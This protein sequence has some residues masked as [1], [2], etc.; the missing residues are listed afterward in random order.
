MLLT[1][2]RHP[3]VYYTLPWI[4]KN[5]KRNGGNGERRETVFCFYDFCF[6][7]FVFSNFHSSIVSYIL[8]DNVIII[9]SNEVTR[10]AVSFDLTYDRGSVS[11]ES[12]LFR[13]SRWPLWRGPWTR[14]RWIL[15]T[16][17]RPGGPLPLKNISPSSPFPKFVCRIARADERSRARRDVE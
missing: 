6:L 10:R 14:T 4:T 1:Y 15:G 17:R 13:V 3:P 11:A 7:F 2:R 8:L 5:P 16:V 12:S 9:I